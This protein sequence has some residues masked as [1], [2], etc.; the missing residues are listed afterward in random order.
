MH[1]MGMTNT[2]LEATKQAL[3]Q[4]LKHE[5]K[6]IRPINP[7][8]PLTT[9]PHRLSQTRRMVKNHNF[10]LSH[11]RN[12]SFYL[13]GLDS[14][15]PM[16][17]FIT[18]NKNIKSALIKVTDTLWE[19]KNTYALSKDRNQNS[20]EW[21]PFFCEC[22][23]SH[24]RVITDNQME[25]DSNFFYHLFDTFHSIEKLAIHNRTHLIIRSVPNNIL[26]ELSIC[27]S[28]LTHFAC[29]NETAFEKFP[30]LKI[31]KLHYCH[32][33]SELYLKHKYLEHVSFDSSTISHNALAFLT[34]HCP[35]LRQLSINFCKELKDIGTAIASKT[36]EELSL[37][38]IPITAQE[39]DKILRA[40]PNLKKIIVSSQFISA[41]LAL[42]LEHEFPGV[43]IIRI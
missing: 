31:L 29:D 1:T 6:M 32:G 35:S 5:L 19:T 37:I 2:N 16:N 38:T 7:S 30:H 26:Q 33:L 43:S 14:T 17:A 25:I 24:L 8:R 20:F 40:C 18:K 9:L 42:W 12:T 10:K 21:G 13:S 11:A 28:D 39:L 27:W 15:H 22:E 23:N 3:A 4:R 36:L 41:K 34:Q